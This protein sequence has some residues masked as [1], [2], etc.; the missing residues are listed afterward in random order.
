MGWLHTQFAK[1]AA[2]APR[3]PLLIVPPEHAPP[4]DQLATVCAGTIVIVSD[5][6]SA[7]ACVVTHRDDEVMIAAIIEDMGHRDDPHAPY[8]GDIL[9]IAPHHI[10]R[11]YLPDAMGEHP[12]K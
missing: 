11:I 10:L 6:K 12:N 2:S 3:A 4:C 7:F 1:F 8:L 9:R 5:T